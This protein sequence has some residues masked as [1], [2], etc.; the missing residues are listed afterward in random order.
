MNSSLYRKLVRKIYSQE[1][2]RK[3]MIDFYK[4][5]VKHHFN[6]AHKTYDEYCVM[7][8]DASQRALELLVQH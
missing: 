8:N 5:K 4:S 7:Q 3:I 2:I 6:K 1:F